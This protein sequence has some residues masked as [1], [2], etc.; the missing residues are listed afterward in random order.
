MGKALVIEG[1]DR[2]RRTRGGTGPFSRFDAEW[3]SAGS[4][5]FHD[6]K[7]D[8]FPILAH[9]RGPSFGFFAELCSCLTGC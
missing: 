2:K 3:P 7:H 5:W 6:I 9:R 1:M 4:G 8:G